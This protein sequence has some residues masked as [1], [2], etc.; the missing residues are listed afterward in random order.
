ETMFLSWV[1][2]PVEAHSPDRPAAA[3]QAQGPGQADARRGGAL[4]RPRLSRLPSPLL[5][6]WL[7]EGRAKM[8][9]GFLEVSLL[10]GGGARSASE[11]FQRRQQTQPL[12]W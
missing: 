10:R 3:W 9:S 8:I 12:P 6:R 7:Q 2:S 5:L 4:L 1:P 11:P